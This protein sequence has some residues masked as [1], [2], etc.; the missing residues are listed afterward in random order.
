M[1]RILIADGRSPVSVIQDA[2][3]ILEERNH[4]VTVTLSGNDVVQ[5]FKEEES[6]PEIIVLEFALAQADGF[7]VLE[8]IKNTV[9]SI[10][11]SIIWICIPDSSGTPLLSWDNEIISNYVLYPYRPWDLVLAAEQL[12]YKTVKPRS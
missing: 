7:E 2:R 6:C 4:T 1:A 5:S 8:M 10:S 9:K 12:V 3:K 11:A